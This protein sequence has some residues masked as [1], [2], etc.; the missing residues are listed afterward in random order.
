M[1]IIS[2]SLSPRFEL[3]KLGWMF[4]LLLV[5]NV[6]G[7]FAGD[8]SPQEEAALVGMRQS[9][10]RATGVAPTPEDEQKMLAEWKTA[11]IRDAARLSSTAAAV[12]TP[13]APSVGLP[14]SSN[15]AAGGPQNVQQML[16]MAMQRAQSAGTASQ[17]PS[18]VPSNAM[19]ND[20]ELLQKIAGLHEPVKIELSARR[21]GLLVNGRVFADPEGAMKVYSY[22]VVSGDVTYKIASNGGFVFKY[23]NP[24][25][26][27]APVAI[28]SEVISGS[29]IQINLLNGSTLGGDSVILMPRGMLV[30]RGA[31]I[32]IYEPGKTI[33]TLSIPDGWMLAQFQRGSVG[34]TRTVLL[35][36]VSASNQQ[37][38]S[39]G[40]GALISS[41]QALGQ[42]LGVNKKE[43][44]AFFN[45]DTG[46]LIK[47][48]ITVDGKTQMV[49]SNCRKRNNF[50]ND[51]A[52]ATSFQSLYAPDGGRN[53]LH[54][55]WQ[56]NWYQTATGPIGVVQE[57]GTSDLFVMDLNTGRRVTAFHRSLGMTSTDSSQS[58]D[59]AVKVSASW[60]FQDHVIDDAASLLSG[61]SDVTSQAVKN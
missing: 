58:G 5:A 4:S 6:S 40:F 57:G 54:Y 59:G 23:F 50:V 61:N 24:S 7:A 29:G 8:R 36:N 12:A 52:T 15:S 55:F 38:D 14:A 53:S 31:N 32:F 9:Y 1:S 33:Q 51:C 18:P 22:D 41:T 43:D 47:L 21:D 11:V 26:G 30:A 2:Y 34:A 3:K 48:N 42:L 56:A 20:G 45:L 19:M 27:V 49:M 46:K 39:S 16:Q 13:A 17:L 10:I 60:M 28:G 44:Y 37:K 25:T 35:E